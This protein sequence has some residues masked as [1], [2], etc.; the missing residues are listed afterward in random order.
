MMRDFPG[1][2]REDGFWAGRRERADSNIT[3]KPTKSRRVNKL[4]L[5]PQ[6]KGKRNII[7]D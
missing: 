6:K 3:V 7:T 4:S 5:S 1:E 2:D